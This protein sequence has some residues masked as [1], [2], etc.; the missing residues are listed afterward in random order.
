MP[1]FIFTLLLALVAVPIWANEGSEEATKTNEKACTALAEDAKRDESKLTEEAKQKHLDNCPQFQAVPLKELKASKDTEA[2][3]TENAT[4]TDDQ[5]SRG[6]DTNTPPETSREAESPPT[7]PIRIGAFAEGD[8]PDETQKGLGATGEGTAFRAG[9]LDQQQ[10]REIP[11]SRYDD[12]AYLQGAAAQKNELQQTLAKNAEPVRDEFGNQYTQEGQRIEPVSNPDL[13]NSVHT[14]EETLRVSLPETVDEE[15]A[16][17][18]RPEFQQVALSGRYSIVAQTGVDGRLSSPFG[19][20][21]HPIYGDRRFHAGVDMAAAEGTPVRSAAAGTV[22]FAGRAGGYGNLVIVKHDSGVET[23]Y[24]H[25][26]DRI[27]MPLVGTRVNQGDLV[28]GVGNTGGSTGNHLHYEV[29]IG[30]RAVDP[31]GYGGDVI[32]AL[33]NGS[34]MPDWVGNMP[35]MNAGGGGVRMGNRGFTTY[36]RGQG[37]AQQYEEEQFTPMYFAP[38]SP[39]GEGNTTGP[40]APPM[41]PTMQ[42]PQNLTEEELKKRSEEFKKRQELINAMQP[43]AVNPN[44]LDSTKLISI[45]NNDACKNLR[46]ADLLSKP[47]CVGR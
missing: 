30:G 3:P 1:P 23:R 32:T 41:A 7:G 43:N 20:R 25:L 6:T 22:T 9:Y 40:V 21:N 15:R 39:G 46:G 4:V 11:E 27:D 31:A 19:W 26:T 2:R 36:A 10:G 14:A 8:Y 16:G 45:L 18:E 47:E 24:A 12:Q 17:L 29:R 34:P 38:P 33:N 35:S 28:G 44:L 42:Q 13:H 5:E 37:Y